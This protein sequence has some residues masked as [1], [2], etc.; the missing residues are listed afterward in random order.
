[1]SQDDSVYGHRIDDLRDFEREYR[2]RLR[3]HLEDCLG[4]LDA[5]EDTLPLRAAARRLGEASDADLREVF[6]DLDEDRRQHLLSVLVRIP[7]P[8]VAQ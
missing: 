5:R 8:E 6:A 1:M 2:E 3:M 4:T 7:V